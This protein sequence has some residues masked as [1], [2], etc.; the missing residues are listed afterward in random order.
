MTHENNALHPI[1]YRELYP[2]PPEEI[3]QK[4]WGTEEIITRGKD[5]GYAIKIMHLKAGHQVSLHW[6]AQKCETF[7]L[8]KGNLILEI[9]EPSSDKHVFLLETPF[10]SITLQPQTP[11]TFYVP[12]GQKEETI[13][14]ESSTPDD[15]ND[16]YRLTKSGPRK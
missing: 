4:K 13:F 14:I 5:T 12:D 11:H 2:S 6:H 3:V 7:I 9:L 1:H 8:I 15:P 16:N 10:S